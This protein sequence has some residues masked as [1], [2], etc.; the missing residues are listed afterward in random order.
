MRENAFVIGMTTWTNLSATTKGYGC[1]ASR[2]Q[3]TRVDI[4]LK[5]QNPIHLPVKTQ[6]HLG[7]DTQPTHGN[8]VRQRDQI[9]QL[10]AE[11]K[12]SLLDF[13]QQDHNA[14]ARYGNGLRLR[15]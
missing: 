9:L 10:H 5:L 14:A 6:N 1:A 15:A 13:R 3:C 4:N 8:L 12:R 2:D 11:P 7:A